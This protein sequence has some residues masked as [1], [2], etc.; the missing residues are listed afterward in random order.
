MDERSETLEKVLKEM[1]LMDE[2]MY[3]KRK[4]DIRG[5]DAD[6]AN[7]AKDKTGTP[8]KKKADVPDKKEVDDT[9][10]KKEVSDT[11][12]KKMRIKR[13]RI[14]CRNCGE[15][16][17]S[18]SV[19]DFVTCSCGRCSADGGH[20]YLSRSFLKSQDDYEELSEVEEVR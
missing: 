2:R 14:R 15:I 13:N 8:A 1:I 17:E 4:T 12:V 10:D 11:P 16:I 18:K 19:H 6:D 20:D 7:S 3:G 9:P 5:T